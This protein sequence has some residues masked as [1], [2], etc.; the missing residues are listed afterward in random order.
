MLL[1]LQAGEFIYEQPAP[2]GVEYTFKH[3][4]TQEVAY[5]SLLIER[6]KL[7]HERAA[8]AMEPLYSDQLDSHLSELAHHY[9]HSGNARKAVQ[10]LGRA[11]RQALE[12]TAYPETL[13]LLTKGLELLK[14]LPD[15]A[16]RALEEL[17]LQNALGWLLYATKGPAVAEREIAVVRAKELCEQLGDKARLVEALAAL[18]NFRFN[19][20]EL[21]SARELAEQALRLAEHVEDVGI[22]A[23]AHFQ[24]G[25]VLFWQGEFAAARQ[26]SERALELFGSS[27]CR[28]FWEAENARY[29]NFY[30]VLVTALLGYPD[31]ALKRSREALDVARRSSDPVAI[32]MALQT[33]AWANW[34]V[35][36][37]GTVL[38]RTAEELAIATEQSMPLHM[39]FGTAFRAWAQAAQRQSEEGVAKLQVMVEEAMAAGWEGAILLLSTLLAECHR[40]SGRF[41][42]AIELAAEMLAH[43]LKKGDIFFV[44]RLHQIQGEVLMGDAPTATEAENC[45]RRAIEIARSQS[46]KLLEL[47]ATTSLAALFAKKGR[48]EEARTILA[49]IYGWFTEGFD[50]ADLKEAKALLEELNA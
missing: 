7:L 45:F 41:K 14:E 2:A 42:E 17:D 5:N 37:A 19:R 25:Q 13:A 29:S 6:R 30:P 39:F 33:D 1:D 34:I 47:R 18:S 32:A 35:R 20:A 40:T 50:T 8:A 49:E 21:Q 28:T 31:T 12:R 10:Y 43:R 4:L 48:R 11:G 24:L 26:H 23:Q 36:D 3:A 44:L 16:E 38:E 27:P 22:E 15:D 9:S 46:A